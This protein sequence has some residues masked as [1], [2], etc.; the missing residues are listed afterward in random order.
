[1]HWMP[2]FARDVWFACRALRR[3][4][5]FAAVAVG[6]LGL[7]LGANTAMFSLVNK[8]LIAHLPCARP[9]TPRAPLARHGHAGR[10]YQIPL[11]FFRQLNEDSDLFDGVLCRMAGSER[12]TVGTDAGREPA[13]GE[14]VSGNFFEV[15]GIK[16]HLGR[17]LASTDD[18][19]PGA[20]PV[21]VVSHRHWQRQ[22]GGDPAVIGR[23][24]RFTGV[25]M[26]VIG[27]SPPGFDELDPGQAIDFRFPLAMQT[28]VRQ[29]PPRA[30]SPRPATFADRRIPEMFIVGRLR[31]GVTA[32]QAE[33]AL[34][35]RLER[36]AAEGAP[37]PA[38]IARPPQRERV[39]LEPA[40]TGIGLTRRQ[41]ATSL[42]VMMAVTAAV[43]VIACLNLANLILARGSARAREFAVRVA[44][45]AGSARLAR[46]LLAEN[47]VLALC[48]AAFGACLAYPAS[49]LLLRVMSADGSTPPVTIEPDLTVL[50][51]HGLSTVLAVGL[52]GMVPALASRRGSVP[53]APN[54]Q[55]HRQSGCSTTGVSCG[56]SRAVHRRAR[57]RRTVREDGARAPR[58]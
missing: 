4:P 8:V 34:T 58:D 17:L 36:F 30:G 19:T 51:F 16:P 24:L 1:M 6:T 22:L 10:R 20:H 48:G 31:R 52:F 5:M 27:V 3:Q 57:R 44:I 21:V 9:R 42:R 28:E 37:S 55:P 14:L 50:L 53:A 47:L 33:Q 40:A 45:G 43:L 7:A 26:T 32:E 11:S 39:R 54:R 15:L 49:A 56:A 2:D 29:G 35:L 25:S 13:L 18:V 23:T 46:Q 41:Y 38:D 12:V